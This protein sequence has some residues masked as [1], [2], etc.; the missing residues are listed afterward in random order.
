M[1]YKPYCKSYIKV[2]KIPLISIFKVSYIHFYLEFFKKKKKKRKPYFEALAWKESCFFFFI[3]KSYN[4][5]HM[6]CSSDKT[7]YSLLDIYQ[8]HLVSWS[9]CFFLK[10]NAFIIFFRSSIK[11]PLV[12]AQY[13]IASEK[14]TQDKS[15]TVTAT[16]PSLD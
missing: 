1:L 14:V 9:I 16:F 6:K 12:T 5:L 4:N 8:K 3:C 7:L 10:N 2:Y 13:Q 11:V 15:S